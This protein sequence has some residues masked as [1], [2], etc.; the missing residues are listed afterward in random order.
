M[1][2]MW[3]GNIT[4]GLVN[5]PVKLYGA[6]EDLTAKTHHLHGDDGGRVSQRWVCKCCDAEVAYGD[7]SSC[8][9][10]TD[11]TIVELTREELAALP[12]APKREMAIQEF[13]DA[14]EID[15]LTLSKPYYVA[16]GD[17]SGKTYALLREAMRTANRFAIVR[18][19]LRTRESLALLRVHDDM[20]TMQT[21][22]W[23]NELRDAPALPTADAVSDEELVMATNLIDAMTSKWDHVSHRNGYH[24]AMLEL[25]ASKRAATGAPADTDAQII[26]LNTK[27]AQRVAAHVG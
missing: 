1:R 26:D 4:F 11:G 14:D 8:Y 25:V 21:V 2:S 7:L 6:T 5:V 9:E 22:L 19:V 3:T 15:P 10:D 12:Q 16:P 13:V 24:A 18:V 23:A 17:K 27:L 20:I